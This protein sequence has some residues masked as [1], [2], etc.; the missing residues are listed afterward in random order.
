MLCAHTSNKHE[1]DEIMIK[2]YCPFYR[3]RDKLARALV[4]NMSAFLFLIFLWHLN[5][6]LIEV[7]QTPKI[8][9]WVIN[10]CFL[11]F[12]IKMWYQDPKR[13]KDAGLLRDPD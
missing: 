9:I 7:V 3:L 4:F 10:F 11:K 13:E 2:Y 1:F 5:L 8:R 6:F 12:A